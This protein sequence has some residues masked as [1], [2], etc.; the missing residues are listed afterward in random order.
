MSVC[1]G[2]LCPDTEKDSIYC[3]GGNKDEKNIP[4]QE[5]PEKA[6]ARLYEENGDEEL[7]KGPRTPP[8][9]GQKKTF[10]LINDGTEKV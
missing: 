9:K 7:Q 4:A 2:K 6:R 3:V 1:G 8:R 10:S 5:A